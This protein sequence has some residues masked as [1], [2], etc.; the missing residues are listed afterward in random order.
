MAGFMTRLQGYVYDGEYLATTALVNGQFVNIVSN[1]ATALAAASNTKAKIV[2]IEGPFGM[3]GVRAEVVTQGDSEVYIVENVPATEST[4]VYN[5]TTF[6]PAINEPARIHRLM[7]GEEFLVSSN[8]VSP[9]GFVVG[10]WFWVGEAAQ[11]VPAMEVVK[12]VSKVVDATGPTDITGVS[13]ETYE[14]AEGDTIH[15]AVTVENTGALLLTA[16]ALED[17][18][19]SE[20]PVAIASLAVG[21]TTTPTAYTHV[22]TAEE[23][24]TVVINTAQATCAHPRQTGTLM[25]YDVASVGVVAG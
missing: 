1:K 18:M 10:D 21:A 5:E 13:L 16:I 19:N 3:A 2:A 22:V 9:T 20:S 8:V 7:S 14:L 6:G 25:A 24:G 17:E 11:L 12:I 15:Y 23:A 4:G